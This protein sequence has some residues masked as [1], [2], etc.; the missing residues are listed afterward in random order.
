MYSQYID[1]LKKLPETELLK[2]ARIYRNSNIFLVILWVG[3]F[4]SLKVLS[5]YHPMQPCPDDGPSGHGCGI[6]Q[7]YL[8]PIFVWVLI[9]IPS[10]FEGMAGIKIAEVVKSR[11]PQRK[12]MLLKITSYALTAWTY[13]LI[14]FPISALLV[15]KIMRI[16]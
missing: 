8:A 1:K 14:T 11:F 9:Y 13:L 12:I 10:L 7:E 16:E 2:K 6:D 4:I 3:I 5:I 15:V